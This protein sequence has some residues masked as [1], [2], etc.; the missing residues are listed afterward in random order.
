MTQIACF[1][2]AN[3]FSTHIMIAVGFFTAGFVS[4][5]VAEL[6]LPTVGKQGCRTL[7]RTLFSGTALGQGAPFGTPLADW[8]AADFKQIRLAMA[9]CNR[10]IFS[11]S[12]SEL[13]QAQA[14]S[15]DLIDKIEK[16]TER[17]KDREESR[18]ER[19]AATDAHEKLR[20]ER[21]RKAEAQILEDREIDRK[22]QREAYEASVAEFAEQQRR[23]DAEIAER[24]RREEASLKQKLIDEEAKMGEARKNAEAER[25][26]KLRPRLDSAHVRSDSTVHFLKNNPS[27]KEFEDLKMVYAALNT[28]K[29]MFDECSA[30]GYDFSNEKKENDRRLHVVA[31]TLK[32]EFG[33][34][35]PLSQKIKPQAGELSA[36]KLNDMMA[37]SSGSYDIVKQCRGQN[38]GISLMAN[39]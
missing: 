35:D 25:L 31:L 12:A 11:D 27:L 9:A 29:R 30:R 34:D 1:R 28:A 18:Q 4:P 36:D 8:S 14:Q 38:L 7:E 37:L 3:S 15:D 22:A 13:R 16:N 21:I 5:A 19:R 33:S 17:T 39:F 20:N 24:R 10:L 26:A 2:R 6:N 23:E 32:E